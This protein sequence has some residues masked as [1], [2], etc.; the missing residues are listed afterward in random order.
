MS[1]APMA[2]S[3]MPERYKSVRCRMYQPSAKKSAVNAVGMATRT[4]AE[5]LVQPINTNESAAANSKKMPTKSNACS[6]RS[7]S[8]VLQKRSRRGTRGAG[9]EGGGVAGAGAAAV[10]STA[11][12]GA[13]DVASSVGCPTGGY[14]AAGRKPSAFSKRSCSAT[15]VARMRWIAFGDITSRRASKP[16]KNAST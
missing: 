14:G 11:V 16:F 6:V 1:S 12:S 7:E 5:K 13:G 10:G 2:L 4:G 8:S 15:I 9:G 3:A